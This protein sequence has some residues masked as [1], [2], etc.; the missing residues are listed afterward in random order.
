MPESAILKA[1]KDPSQVVKA[2]ES[3][4]V[5]DNMYPADIDSLHQVHCLNA[6]RKDI[7]YQYYYGTLTR[8][9]FYLA[10]RAHCI[11]ILLQNLMCKADTELITMKWVRKNSWM[12]PSERPWPDFNVGKKCRNYDA[13]VEWA[14]THQIPDGERKRAELR[15]PEG[16]NPTDFYNM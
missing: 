2:P 15:M 13:L 14:V 4:G 1:G 9:K 10:H 11:H 16:N 7:F 5:G 3:W 12:N 8:S 6:L